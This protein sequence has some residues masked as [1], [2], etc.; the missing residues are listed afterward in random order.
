MIPSDLDRV[1]SELRKSEKRFRTVF[2]SSALGIA[3][4]DIPTG[5][6]LPDPDTVSKTPGATGMH[7]NRAWQKMLGYSLE[8][9]YQLGIEKL[10]PPEDTAKDLLLFTKLMS[11]E[12]DDYTIE[13]RYIKKDGSIM[14][15]KFVA[16]VGR[17]DD[18]KPIIAVGIVEDITLRKRAEEETIKAIQIRENFIALA[19]HELRT[20]ITPLKLQV[21][22]LKR[23]LESEGSKIKDADKFTSLLEDSTRKLDRMNQL[24]NDM[25]DVLAISADKFILRPRTQFDL[26]EL[27][28]KVVDQYATVLQEAHCPLSLILQPAIG[29]WDRIRIEQALSNLLS[30]ALKFARGKPIEIEVSKIGNSA[31]FRI[32]DHG[33]GISAEGISKVFAKFERG[34]SFREHP[35]LGLGLYITHEIAKLHGGDVAVQSERGKRTTFILSLPG[36]E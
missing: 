8:E 34:V 4:I 26:S 30:N 32:T 35:G 21:V 3:V 13:K 11:G 27:A 5:G 6:G 19:S 12:I 9:L 22:L 31:V 10:S 2:E 15:G 36:V 16:S 24:I 17:D 20:P 28:K 14:W 1:L 23:Y 33:P 18:G 25:L 29:N 7:I